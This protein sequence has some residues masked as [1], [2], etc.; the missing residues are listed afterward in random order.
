MKIQ[1]QGIG[2]DG[3]HGGP[4]GSVYYFEM[5]DLGRR[6]ADVYDPRDIER[7]LSILGLDGRPVWAALPEPKNTRGR[8][9]R[10]KPDALTD[11]DPQEADDSVPVPVETSADT[12]LAT[13]QESSG[14]PD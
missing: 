3:P 2:C 1:L 6:V 11:P 12:G 14:G 4:S 8:K 7:F 10:N 9:S 13:Q 5:D